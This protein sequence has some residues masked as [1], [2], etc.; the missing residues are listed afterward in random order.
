MIGLYVHGSVAF[1]AFVPG[2]SDI[3]FLS[4]C[5]AGTTTGQV[6]KV[7]SVLLKIRTPD[8]TRGVE[9]HLID[10]TTARDRTAPP[11][12]RLFAKG[13]TGFRFNRK[14]SDEDS[15][16]LLMH[17][18][19]CYDVGRAVFGPDPKDLF[20]PP[21]RSRLISLF[22]EELR[23]PKL[24]GQPEYQVLTACRA[25]YY[26]HEGHFVSKIKGAQWAFSKL[27]DRAVIEAALALQRGQSNRSIK[28]AD[29][30]RLVEN[31]LAELTAAN[32][33]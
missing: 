11:K 3:D 20:V 18:A 13:N 26:L 1:D 8:L 14:I 5:S 17:I 23:D 31:V 19:V 6:E 25:L 22:A 12:L 30:R 33:H 32:G 21:S 24:D 10:E 2:K 4:V 7:E 29:V 9:F 27:R 28:K 16:D 15:R